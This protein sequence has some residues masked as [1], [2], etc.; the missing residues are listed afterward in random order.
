MKEVQI[1][2]TELENQR[3]QVKQMKSSD[4]KMW[5]INIENAAIYAV[6]SETRGNL[7]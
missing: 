5:E 1:E 6:L 3:K 4:R 2:I 7:I